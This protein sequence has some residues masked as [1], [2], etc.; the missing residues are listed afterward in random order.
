MT[1]KTSD[2]KQG[3][4]NLTCRLHI[5]SDQEIKKKS[6]L[7]FRQKKSSGFHLLNF[8][9]MVGEKGCCLWSSISNRWLQN[10]E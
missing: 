8:L 2:M 7:S 9:I 6:G 5:F 10:G 1:Q 3:N 4:K